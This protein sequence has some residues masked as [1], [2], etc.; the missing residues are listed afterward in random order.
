MAGNDA[1][2]RDRPIAGLYD[3]WAKLAANI[4][5]PAAILFVTILQIVPSINYGIRV[6]ERVDAELNILA[7]NCADLRQPPTVTIVPSP[8]QPAP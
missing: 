5:I 1:G 4:G 8:P 3:S 2:P 6:A 7:I